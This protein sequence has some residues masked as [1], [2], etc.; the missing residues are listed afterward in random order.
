MSV[1]VVKLITGEEIIAVVSEKKDAV[2]MTQP[3]LVAVQDNRLVFIPYMQYTTAA[4][5]VSVDK[6]HIM[7]VVTPVESLIDDYENATTKVTK[8]RKSITSSVP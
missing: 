3:M 2:E 6:K 4:E 1:Q 5:F 7:F 8:P